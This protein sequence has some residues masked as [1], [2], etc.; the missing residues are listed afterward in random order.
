LHF[1]RLPTIV[2]WPRLA[3]TDIQEIRYTLAGY[4]FFS[5]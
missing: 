4:L 3:F 2:G 5:D 1:I